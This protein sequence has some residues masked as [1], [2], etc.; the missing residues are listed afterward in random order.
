VCLALAACPAE[1]PKGAVATG[2]PEADTASDLRSPPSETAPEAA[3]QPEADAALGSD[4]PQADLVEPDRAPD[5][6]PTEG[7]GLG[8]DYATTP[9]GATPRYEPQATDWMAVG[10]PSDRYRTAG[11]AVDLGN[12]P[13]PLDIDLLDDYLSIGLE[14]LDGFG[15]N[16]CVY[17]ELSGPLDL[18]TLPTPAQTM[19]PA[20]PI[21]LVNVTPASPR[22]GE[23]L[24]LRFGFYDQGDDPYYA[25]H[26]LALRP[27]F[28]RPMAQGETYCAVMTRA[29]KD[30]GARYLQAAP[31][32]AGALDQAPELAPLAKW[33]GSSPLAKADLAV[34]T[35]FT[36]QRATRELGLV[37][38]FLAA[39]DP[40]VVASMFEPGV[41]GEFHG[42]YLAPNFQAGEKPYIQDGGQLELGA[43]G[44]TPIV[45]A[46]EEIRF[47]L[48]VPRD[49]PMPPAGWPIVLY[50]HG[51]G[52]DYETCRGVD[53]ELLSLGLAIL[54]IDQPL[55]GTRAPDPEEPLNESQLVAYSFNF[56]NARA[57]RMM[58]RQAAIDTLVLAR[59]VAEGRFDLAETET[60]SGAALALDPARVYFYGH[61]HGGLSGSL[62]L[63]VEP[64]IQGGV[65]S[66]A[67]GV[68]IETILRRKDP[69]DIQALVAVALSIPQEHMDT[70][71]PLLSVIQMLVDVTDPVNYSPYWLHPMPGGQAKHVFVTEGTADAA[72]P[73]VGTDALAA[74]GGVPLIRPIAKGSE[75]HALEGLAAIDPP[76]T[77]NV[78]TPDGPRTAGVRQ[79][80]GGSH[81][82]ATESPE[83]VAMWMT[84]LRTLS[85][86]EPVTIGVGEATLAGSPAIA[87]SDTC[88]GAKPIVGGDLPV[89]VTGDTT[90]AADDYASSGCG[91]D[92]GAGMRDLVYA[93]TPAESGSYRFQLRQHAPV[94]PDDEKVLTIGPNRLYVV[95]DCGAIGAT[96]LGGLAGFASQDP[97]ANVVELTLSGAQTIYV[98][99]DG[100]GPGDK[101]AFTLAI[102]QTCADLACGERKCGSWGCGSCGTCGAGE[103]CSDG[104]CGVVAEGDRCDAP[105]AIGPSGTW[106]GTTSGLAGDYAIT[107]AGCPGAKDN[108]GEA[109]ADAVHVFTAAVSGLHDL[110]LDADFDGVVYA[111]S[112]TC[113]NLASECLGAARQKS[114]GETLGLELS[115]GQTIYVFVDGASNSSNQAGYYAL[116]IAPCVPECAGK[117]CQGDGCGGSCGTCQP[118]EHCVVKAGCVPIPYDCHPTT[119][120]EVIPPGDECAVAIPVDALPFTAKGSTKDLFPK[121][122]MGSGDCPGMGAAGGSAADVVV[123]FTTPAAGLYDFKLEADFDSALY[124]FSD[125]ADP[126]G[127][128]LAGLENTDK[129]NERIW[130]T[131]EE[132][133]SLFVTVDGR[134]SKDHKGT[135]TLSIKACKPS[136]EGKGC[137]S[138]GCNGDCGGCGEGTTCSSFQCKT[139]L[140][141]GC[142]YPIT[143]G[144][145]PWAH[146]NKTHN[147]GKRYQD[148]CVD[149]PSGDGA[150]DVSYTF[151]PPETKSYRFWVEA[152]FN[153]QVY[154]TKGC[155]DAAG[156]TCLAGTGTWWVDA[157]L[158]AG[159]PVF[160][161]VDGAAGS[162]Q[163]DYTLHAEVTCLPACEGKQCG[164]DGCAGS[165][166]TCHAPADFCTGEGLC[167]DPASIPGNACQTPFVLDG[168][169]LPVT[170]EGDTS[171]A[172]NHYGIDQGHCPPGLSS[173]GLG[174]PDEVWALT[175]LEAGTY[176]VELYP[177]PGFDAALYVA[178][179]CADLEGTCLG[180]DDTPYLEAV[181]F[182][183]EAG[184]T[185]Y[186]IVDGA[187]TTQ[188]DLGAYTL[189]V[190]N[191]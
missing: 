166:G 38:G 128:C 163:G 74:A 36:T 31:D 124:L 184:A 97:G 151:T 142:Q 62:A 152:N 114:G 69:L 172:L 102:R 40:P 154:V 90:L 143:I 164:W 79:W 185:A 45:Q 20:A 191:P 169:G 41:F 173:K 78:A 99:V 89:E 14:A 2:G 57:G 1:P 22:F 35:C 177:A 139:M 106:A 100:A 15:L 147:Y 145:V 83:A 7:P 110:S 126:T 46:Q 118:G 108:L 136:C 21:R 119:S 87:P 133:E 10:W 120:C 137:G 101:G 135:Y 183:L 65:I 88:G 146:D 91:G 25:P 84:F 179:D 96:C 162:E 23:Q 122:A 71:H 70:F 51:T 86:G 64:S 149:P 75:A 104:Q 19:E 168:A 150:R 93:F 190:S 55:H 140:G 121:H 158:T 92:F 49:R 167:V 60:L 72:S 116:Q 82:V 50:S 127:S 47:M 170:V 105:F 125:C 52:G 76:V 175:A 171:D 115:A 144:S 181:S 43:D 157:K 182:E 77:L 63:A 81:W 66:G 9:P 67:A 129:G 109:S 165:C 29:V 123:A 53:E 4:A 174:S 153:A 155:P 68:L 18:A 176:Q 187:S 112:G 161:V 5:A 73:S 111:T 178:T 32:L 12:L 34:A 131:L 42:T 28:G 6:P 130:R 33:L 24:P 138:D 17:F 156:G 85:E 61:S 103:V 3:T 94:H 113:E 134:S 159:E 56:T 58:F 117:T 44:T 16:G 48:L 189:V 141:Y 95:T 37:R 27:V 148:T 59:M 26:T 107:D 11:G 30:A 160:V 8:I 54:C 98:I 180:A 132:G 80:Q 188:A 39:G 186:L 13:N